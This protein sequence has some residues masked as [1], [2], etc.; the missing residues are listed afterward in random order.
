[1]HAPVYVPLLDIE[2]VLPILNRISIFGGLTELQLYNVFRRLQLC[3][4]K[5][6]EIMFR[7]GDLPSHIYVLRRGKIELVLEGK[8][9]A[10]ER[11]V[12]EVGQCF[13]EAAVIGI[14]PHTATAIALERSEVIV[15]SRGALMSLSESDKDLF[16]L[17]VLNIAREVARRLNATDEILLHYLLGE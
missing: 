5:P 3:E 11:A 12:I 16:A 13:G 8:R 6:G 15:L 17:L 4:L 14:Q 1:M 7:K 2:N 10:L 9:Y